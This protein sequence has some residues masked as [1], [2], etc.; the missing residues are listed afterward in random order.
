MRALLTTAAL[1]LLG[2]GGGDLLVAASKPI[3]SADGVDT[4]TISVLGVLDAVEFTTTGGTLSVTRATRDA[5]GVAKT[6]LTSTVVGQV[7]V[8]ATSTSGA[9]GKTNVSFTAPSTGPRLRFRTSP[10]TTQQ[11]NLLR[12][13]PEVAFEDANGA[14]LTSSTA[15]VTVAITPGS[16]A[17][18]LEA[19]S[20]ATVNA[21]QGVASFNGLKVDRV[22]DACTLTATSP[23]TTSAVS[24][25]FDVR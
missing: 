23:S 9:V 12:P 10:G 5:Q 18:V 14:V 22:A 7:T 6:E 4:V 19:T 25:A 3:A 11:M 13:I 24:A 1:T 20:L 8:T 16:C 2:C 17:G 15:P 21:V